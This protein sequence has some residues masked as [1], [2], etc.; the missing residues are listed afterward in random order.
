MRMTILF[1]FFLLIPYM[2]QAAAENV[3]E[4]THMTQS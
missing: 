1:I 4:A 3:S 2:A